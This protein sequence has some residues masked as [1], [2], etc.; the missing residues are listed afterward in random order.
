M[1]HWVRGC[2]SLETK[3]LG[4]IPSDRGGHWWNFSTCFCIWWQEGYCQFFHVSCVSV[5]RQLLRFTNGI[6]LS[7]RGH[8]STLCLCV[9]ADNAGSL[10]ASLMVGLGVLFPEKILA[11]AQR[12]GRCQVGITLEQ[13]QGRWGPPWASVSAH[14]QTT[15]GGLDLWSLWKDTLKGFFFF[16]QKGKM[17][18]MQT[19]SWLT[20]EVRKAEISKL[21][22]ETEQL[23]RRYP[24]LPILWV[25]MKVAINHSGNPGPVPL[26]P[27]WHLRCPT[28]LSAPRGRMFV[29]LWALSPVCRSGLGIQ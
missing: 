6:V 9:S 16:F 1:R 13:P 11:G 25:L 29:S 22:P 27:M 4:Q 28:L 7:I 24:C 14:S 18:M 15:G 12:V 3:D 5:T 10:F 2:P 23:I 8:H 20:D 17:G 26:P 19:K 21:P